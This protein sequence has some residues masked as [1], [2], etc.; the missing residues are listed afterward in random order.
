MRELHV[1]TA[2]QRCMRQRGLLP[3]APSMP[4]LPRESVCPLLSGEGLCLGWCHVEHVG[5]ELSAD[6]TG[7][8]GPSATESPERCQVETELVRAA[9]LQFR[10]EGS[11]AETRP[12]SRFHRTGRL[13]H[14]LIT[15]PHAGNFWRTISTLCQNSLS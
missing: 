8:W 11:V 7:R 14:V 2:A 4:G 15:G 10:A 6:K 9:R 3:P 5:E 1:Q 12:Q 13:T